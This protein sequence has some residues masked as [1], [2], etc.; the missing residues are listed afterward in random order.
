[1]RTVGARRT[2]R[3]EYRAG[4]RVCV[5]PGGGAREE[6]DQVARV[7]VRAH[8]DKLYRADLDGP[9]SR[10]AGSTAKDRMMKVRPRPNCGRVRRSPRRG[11]Q[12]TDG[13]A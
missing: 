11:R 9:R 6:P 2:Q 4:G 13:I 12:R 10:M 5:I 7:I 1:M 3:Y 8:P